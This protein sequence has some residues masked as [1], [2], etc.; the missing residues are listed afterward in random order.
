MLPPHPIASSLGPLV[1]SSRGASVVSMYCDILSVLRFST[2]RPFSDPNA[3][4]RLDDL[5]S[6]PTD[7]SRAAGEILPRMP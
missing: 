7:G 6:E 1:F 2:P 4:P 3:E 5:H